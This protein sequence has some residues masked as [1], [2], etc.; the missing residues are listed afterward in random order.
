VKELLRDRLKLREDT[1]AFQFGK[2]A[3]GEISVIDGLKVVVNLTN[4]G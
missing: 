2:P 4:T 1:F 3:S